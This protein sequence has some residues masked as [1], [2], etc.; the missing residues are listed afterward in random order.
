MDKKNEKNSIEMV[1]GM[2]LPNDTISYHNEIF[3]YI[4][5]TQSKSNGELCGIFT[6]DE[7]ECL[8]PVRIIRS[9]KNRK[10]VY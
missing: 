6:N 8:I 2:L 9:M 10:L 5:K 7:I 3:T 4:G 1:D